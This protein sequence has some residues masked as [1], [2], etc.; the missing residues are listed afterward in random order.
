MFMGRQKVSE[1]LADVKIKWVKDIKS[2]R[3]IPF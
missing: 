2:Y 1:A 3:S